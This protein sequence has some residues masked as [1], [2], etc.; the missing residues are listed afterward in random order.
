MINSVIKKSK[1]DPQKQVNTITKQERT[2]LIEVLKGFELEIKKFRPIEEAIITSG[3]IKIKE[4]NQ[5]QWNQKSKRTIFCR[6]NNRCRQLHRRIQFANSIFNW[7]CS[8]KNKNL[9]I[10][11]REDKWKILSQ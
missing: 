8:W 7:I 10:S 11:K 3:G 9:A 1:I 5:K 4:I 6:R 2:R